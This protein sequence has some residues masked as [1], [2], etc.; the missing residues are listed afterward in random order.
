MNGT[1]PNRVYVSFTAE[2]VPATV[3]PL[4]GLCTD[5]ANKGVKE[6]YLLL[7]TPGGSVMHGIAAHNVL[8]ALP[9]KLIT[10]N[11]GSVDSIGNV[12]FL[13]GVER[14]SCKNAT[15]MFHGVARQIGQVASLEEKALRECLDSVVADQKKI[16]AIISDRTSISADE[17]EKLFLEAVT[18]DPDYAKTHGIISDIREVVIPPGAPVQQLVFKR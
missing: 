17:V 9:V 4:L 8:R 7:S 16:G 1:I 3:E 10:H 12:V 15:F 18:R 13:A 5:L 11:V 14:F 6:I 2:I